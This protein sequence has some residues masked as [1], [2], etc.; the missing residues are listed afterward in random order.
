MHSDNVL[1][2][3]CVLEKVTAWLLLF[4]L[5]SGLCCLPACVCVS[6]LADTSPCKMVR[7]RLS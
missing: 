7:R 2:S 5:V 3:V 4:R 6:Q 1:A